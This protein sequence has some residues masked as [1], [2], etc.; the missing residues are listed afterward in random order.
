MEIREIIERVDRLKP[1]MIDEEQKIRWLS[2]VDG[3]VWHEIITQHE[4]APM[5]EF[6][7]YTDTTPPQTKLLVPFPYDN[8]YI[9][10]LS[11]QIDLYNQELG[12]YNNDSQLYNTALK[13][14]SDWYTAHH[15]PLGRKHWRV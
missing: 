4:G 3:Q 5:E 1:N 12:K 14:Y 6:T 9:H 7:G 13:N 15:M 10:Y 11:A 8:L 2:E